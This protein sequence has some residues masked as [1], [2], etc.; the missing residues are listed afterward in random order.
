MVVVTKDA[1]S[2]LRVTGQNY[3]S[4]EAITHSSI[5]EKGMMGTQWSRHR[6]R[7]IREEYEHD[8]VE[9]RSTPRHMKNVHTAM[10]DKLT[11]THQ[12]INHPTGRPQNTA[13]R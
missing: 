7:W 11:V 4:I 6:A 1:V 5:D 13:T 3:S 8:A 9:K 10:Q 2:S 12:R